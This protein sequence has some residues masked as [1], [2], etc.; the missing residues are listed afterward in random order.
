MTSMPTRARAPL[1]AL[2]ALFMMTACGGGGSA[3]APAPPAATP[4]PTP[5]LTVTADSTAASPDGAAVPLHA[6]VNASSAVPSWTLTGPGSLSAAAGSDV[7]YVPPTG[8][9][10]VDGGTATIVVAATGLTSQTITIA[11]SAAADQP[12]RHWTSVLAPGVR[13]RNVVSDGSLYVALGDRG[14]LATSPDGRTWT[15]YDTGDDDVLTVAANGP[16]GWIA[17]GQ[18]HAVVRSPDG[19][20]WTARPL[21]TPG[22][23]PAAGATTMAVGNGHYVVAGRGGSTETV[24]GVTWHGIGKQLVTVAFG[25]GAFVGIDNTNHMLRST[26]AKQWDDVT[27]AGYTV[28]DDVLHALAFSRGRFLVANMHNYATSTDGLAWTTFTGTIA[29]GLWPAQDGFFTLCPSPL[30]GNDICLS[31]DG[32]QWDDKTPINITDPFAGVAG[33]ANSWVRVSRLGGIEWTPRLSGAWTNVVPDTIGYLKAVDYAAGRI[34]AVSSI[35]WALS[36]ADGQTWNT[37]YTSPFAGH[38]GE[39]FTPLALA[40]RG[41]VLVA[42]GARGTDANQP[43]GGR[44]VVSTDGGLS[45]TI[46]TDLPEPVRAV[47]DDGQ[48]F[49]A[50]GDSGQVWRSA[51]G[52]GWNNLAAVAGAPSLLALAHGPGRYVAVGAAGALVTSTDDA[53]WTPVAPVG[54][55]ARY[56]FATVVFDGKQFV[57]AGSLH[58][59]PTDHFAP[60][61][62]VQTSLDGVLWLTQ[63]TSAS[64]WHGLAYHDGEYVLVDTDG[65]LFSS[66]DLKIWTRRVDAT[67]SSFMSES[68][69]DDLDLAGLAWGPDLEAVNFV[70]GQFIAVGANEK[71]IGSSR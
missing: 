40:H 43:S 18:N 33:D 16:A 44:A 35:G 24:D 58:L 66:R 15:T 61:G 29:H 14:R 26:D 56:D 70:N 51:D 5:S 59:I 22:T 65:A 41:N 62:V 8:E 30:W 68:S 28:G 71:V 54:D 3:P 53:T 11:V 6:V 17:I 38:P 48:R 27:P 13:W 4:S 34:V 25:N 7:R 42:V 10:A 31:S 52:N 60:D 39:I 63:A 2:A 20:T 50:V 32:L 69:L 57:R 46:A 21:G 23:T 45:W 37:V 49:V 36:T 12:G 9:E 47:I 19:V 55:D 67:T 1:A 64:R